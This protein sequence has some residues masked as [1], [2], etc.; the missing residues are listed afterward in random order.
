MS[1]YQQHNLRESFHALD[2]SL[3]TPLKELIVGYAKALH[4]FEATATN[5]LSLK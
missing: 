3:Q 2:T 4:N 5:M 1:Y